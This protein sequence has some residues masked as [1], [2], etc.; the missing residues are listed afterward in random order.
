[1]INQW[2]WIGTLG[3]ENVDTAGTGGRTDEHL[4]GFYRAMLLP[5]SMHSADYAVARCLSVRPCLHLSV[6][7][8]H[9]GILS[10]QLKH[11]IRL[12]HRRVAHHS[13]CCSTKHCGNIP[14]RT[15]PT[16]AMNV[17]YEKIAI[18]EQFLAVCQKCYK[19]GPYVVAK[20]NMKP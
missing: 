18:F 4:T 7:Q 11:I 12:C 6:S 19:I 20:T 13:S 16:G 14:T 1:L 17:G 5:C 9:A 10:K 3:F 8:S 15:H 2:S